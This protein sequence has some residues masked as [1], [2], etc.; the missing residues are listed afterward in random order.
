MLIP[1]QQRLSIEKLIELI[2][3]EKNLGDEQFCIYTKNSEVIMS[4]SLVVYI[5]NYPEEDADGDDLFSDF[6]VSNELE[7]YYYGDQFIDV[8]NNAIHQK[9]DVTIDQIIEAGNFY[10]ENDNFITF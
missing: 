10:L 1:R 5:D 9:P 2:L 7:L 4:R 6:V 3:N 8:V